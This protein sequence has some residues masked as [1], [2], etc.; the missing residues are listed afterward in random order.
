MSDDAASPL[1][2][3]ARFDVFHVAVS[4]RG[5]FGSVYDVYVAFARYDQTPRPLC[6]VTVGNRI[7][8]WLHTDRE[9]R[10]QGIAAEIMQGL[11][12]LVGP[13]EHSG[14]TRSGRAFVKAFG[15]ATAAQ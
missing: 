1:F 12:Q 13:L 10:R 4:H 11:E 5:A 15:K 6:T 14:V 3:T 8:W 7:V 2:S 9:H